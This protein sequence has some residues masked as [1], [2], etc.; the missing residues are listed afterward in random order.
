LVA[1]LPTM[2]GL[3]S[4]YHERLTNTKRKQDE[5]KRIKKME[6]WVPK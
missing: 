4:H 6:E 1:E 3:T 5:W 2:G